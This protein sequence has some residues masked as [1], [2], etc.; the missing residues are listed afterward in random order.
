MK[1]V[2]VKLVIKKLMEEEG[3]LHARYG[4]DIF[5]DDY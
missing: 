4:D 3:A 5:E 2:V 1:L